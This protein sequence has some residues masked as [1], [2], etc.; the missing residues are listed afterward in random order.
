MATMHVG[1]ACAATMHLVPQ[2]MVLAESDV[3]ECRVRVAS[4]PA[5]AASDSDNG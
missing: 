4:H 3:E 1:D 5:Y 2:L